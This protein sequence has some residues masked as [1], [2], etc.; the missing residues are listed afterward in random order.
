M[1]FS[2]VQ[3]ENIRQLIAD[4]ESECAD[5]RERHKV[6]L[7][8]PATIIEVIAGLELRNKLEFIERLEKCISR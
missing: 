5:L 8:K 4:L 3:L 2:E 1:S 7:E 6:T